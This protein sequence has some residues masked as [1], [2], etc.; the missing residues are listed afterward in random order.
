MLCNKMRRSCNTFYSELNRIDGLDTFSRSGLFFQKISSEKR[1]NS[2]VR[3]FFKF[4]FPA[5]L[6]ILLPFKTYSI[7]AFALT[8]TATNVTCHGQNS[9][10]IVATVSE[11]SGGTITY[12]LT[13]GSISN[14]TGLFNNLV[15]GTYSVTADDGG[16]TVN[17][18]IIVTE[19]PV[20][21]NPSLTLG[22][23][24][25]ICPS[26][27]DFLLNYGSV[28]GSPVTYTISSGIPA[29]PGFVAVVDGIFGTT[30]LSVP[31]PAGVTKGTYQFFIT[32]KN[33]T[34]CESVVQSFTLLIDDVANPVFNAPNP[35][36]VYYDASGNVNTL[37][38]ITGS[39]SSLS[40][41]C[42]TAPSL[43]LT[44]VDGPAV[45]LNGGC[46]LPYTIARNWRL[47]DAAGNF[48]EK[49]QI[50]TVEDKISPI[51]TIPQ[52]LALSCEQSILPAFTGTALATDN[53][54]SATITYVDLPAIGGCAG[55]QIITRTWTA[56]DCSGNK[57]SGTQILTVTD[58]TKP[59]GTILNKSVGCPADVPSPYINMTTFI[60]DGGTASDN[61]GA[62]SIALF[63]E[64]S[65]GLEGKPGYCPTSVIRIYR[66]S[67]PCGNYTDVVQTIAVL[68]EC[69]CSKC[70][71]GT[72]FHMVDLLGQPTGSASVLDQK[73]NGACCVES[74][75]I[76]FNVRLD[77]D[78]IGVE[79]LING[80]TPSPQDWRI[81]CT[82]VS[83]SGNVICLP[84]GT[85]HLF[86]YCKPG[87]NK[88][89]FTFRSVPGIIS[90]GNITTRVECNGQ[91]S[92]TGIVS[93]PVW[94]SISPGVKGQ[95]NSYLS[96]TAIANP[97]FTAD[98]NAP[99]II[100]YEICGNIGTTICNAL[101][102]DCA[103]ATVYVKQKIGL[104]WNTD[105]AM[106]CLGNMP[107][108]TANISPAGNYTYDWYNGHGASG[109]LIPN[110]TATYNPSVPGPYSVRVTDVQS[111]VSCNVATFDFDVTIDNVGPTLLVP[112]QPLLILSSDPTALQQISDWLA[113]ASASYTKPDGTVVTIVPSNNF[114]GINLQCNSVL[115]VT[116]SAVDQ[117]GNV[118][119]GTSTITVSDDIK[120]VIA[121]PANV[122]QTALPGNC[123]LVN[124]TIP[125]PV[126][127]DNCSV[128]N[129]TWTLSGATTGSSPSSGINS[130]SGQTFN[131]G[132]TKVTYLVTDGAGNT[133][134]CSFD[135]WIK[136]LV[137]PV[138]TSG[139]PVDITQ[140]IGPGLCT[141]FIIVPKPVVNDPCNEGYTVIN[142]FNNSDNAT[143][144]YPV[145]ETIVNWTITDLSGNIT[146]C[147]Q[148]VMVND[149][150]KP[151]LTCPANVVQT[152][153]AGNC[154]LANVTIPDPIAADNCTIKSLTWTLSGT[155]NGNSPATGINT[156][157]GN[158][159]NVGITTVTYTVTDIAGNTTSCSFDVWIKDLVKPVFTSG[160]PSSVTQTTD[161]GE[162]TALVTVAKPV[163]DDPCNEG[164]TIINSFNNTDDASGIYPVGVTVVVWTISDASGNTT[165]CTQNITVNDRNPNLA[166][167][168]SVTVMADFEKLFASNVAIAA[169]IFGDD[170]AGYRLIWSMAGSTS[171]NSPNTGV[172]IFPS[173][174][175]FNLGVTTIQ[176]TLT[177]SNGHSV[178]CSFTV[179]VLSKPDIDCQPDIS[180]DNDPGFCTASVDPGFPIKLSGAEPTTY[181]WSMS[182][183]TPA[184]GTSSGTGAI[185]PNPYLFNVGVTTISWTA[186]N[187][188][189]SDM[190]SQKITVLD[191]ELPSF[192]APV[193]FNFCVEDLISASIVSNLLKINPAPD[194]FLFKSGS[195]A[196]DLN[197]AN[198]SDNCTPLNQIVLHW[199]I[200]FSGSTPP[201]SI[202]G[203]GQPSL[204]P[205]DI[206]FPGDGTSFLE[207]IHTITYWVVDLAGNESAH[208]SVPIIIRPRPSVSYQ[209][210]PILNN[211]NDTH[212]KNLCHEINFE[213]QLFD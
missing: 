151:I 160:C 30:P 26:S 155:T 93:N 101:G 128:V 95:Y 6:F 38:A 9:G 170:C 143:G 124:V 127:S 125:N 73:R 162:C 159:F 130:C 202:Q 15:A 69:G 169:P 132:I 193:S 113:T 135:V 97:V 85:F 46:T 186:T 103:T 61:C 66:I 99:A 16:I 192:V 206:S 116:F 200:D 190:C 24:P 146:T 148:K 111:G 74:N 142:S 102:T 41:N 137:K 29:L 91:L 198:F 47:T 86:T 107:T 87:A 11:S 13:P 65:N 82:N 110:S 168:L 166:C 20:T 108:L 157:S 104:V 122:I 139:C 172:N 140:T 154:S 92:A 35:I 57:S 134:T 118:T 147:I 71:P 60:A 5:L 75:C 36:T 208:K 17:A 173:T 207:V 33:A 175:I 152:A 105:P 76:A 59:V 109:T 70:T 179:T 55:N 50:I 185:A 98:V 203:T 39:P 197:P 194:Y 136:D 84:G 178:D 62:L 210:R 83:I 211:Y 94:N 3:G 180:K 42:T 149:L 115:N 51:L 22:S 133:A 195:N 121:C 58:A 123:A 78:A 53:S 25:V 100:Q 161:A 188:S 14:T 171:G 177:D 144:T 23:L 156:I 189:G 182:G 56:E 67:D 54:G 28:T 145:G 88:N 19:P 12:T 79:I 209:I 77:P 212:P 183:A 158:S 150:Q 129:Q 10:S 89:D 63:N 45:P 213:Q 106:V 80:A 174:N 131:V 184:S 37:P 187:V 163:V 112:P 81:D 8:L 1:V 40:D 167:P 114:L 120:P 21:S 90:S 141:A 2:L 34:G 205:N 7:N 43:I 72:N 4:L 64:I 31:L 138:F 32:V 176:Y 181:T 153:L 126:V 44:S 96:S 204:Y 165:T 196:F 201:P 27:S 164:Y 117:C 52:D 199:L 49:T 119:N 191:K 18:S 48:G 68:G